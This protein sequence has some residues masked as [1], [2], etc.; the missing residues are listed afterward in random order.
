MVTEVVAV[1]A[2]V[3]L[4]EA[5][6]VAV[7]VLVAVAE[8]VVA[9]VVAVEAVGVVAEVAVVPRAVLAAEVVA[10][11]RV[12]QEQRSSSRSTG[13][14]VSSSLRARRTLSSLSTWSL[15]SLSTARRELP[16]RT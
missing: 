1:E 10:V 3:A 12:V 9:P 13:M 15:A 6:V 4:V 8:A 5:V 16:L 14:R 2:V 7:E 11:Q